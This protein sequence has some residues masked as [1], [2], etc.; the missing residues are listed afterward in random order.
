MTSALSNWQNCA[1]ARKH[2]K[3]NEDGRTGPGVCGNASVPLSH[4]GE[5]RYENWNTH[6]H[7]QVNAVRFTEAVLACLCESTVTEAVFNLP[8]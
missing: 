7:T 6:A 2:Y 1:C 8:V 5:R 3:H 4:S